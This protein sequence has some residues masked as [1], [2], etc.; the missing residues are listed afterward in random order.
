M[1]TS[2]FYR[3][4]LAGKIDLTLYCTGIEYDESTEKDD[5][6]TIHLNNVPYSLYDN[7]AFDEDGLVTVQWG[8]IGGGSIKKEVKIKN[9]EPSFDEGLTCEVKCLDAGRGMK[10]AEVSKV[11]QKVTTNQIAQQIAERNG[12]KFT[13]AAKLTKVW[14]NMPQGNRTDFDMLKYLVSQ[15]EGGDWMAVIKGNQLVIK[16]RDVSQPSTT[17]FTFGDGTGRCLSFKPQIKET[18]QKGDSVETQAQGF[19]MQAKEVVEG[20]ANSSTKQTVLTNAKTYKY[21]ANGNEIGTPIAT[22]QKDMSAGTTKAEVN[23]DAKAKFN[24]AGMGNITAEL[25][26]IGEPGYKADMVLTVAGVPKRY[27]GNYYAAGCKHSVNN[28]SWKC[29]FDLKKNSGGGSAAVST[30][31]TVGAGSTPG[32]KTK[33]YVYDAN[34][35]LLP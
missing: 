8:W 33:V 11:F 14:D 32:K 28:D 9:I 2:P 1:G 24:A 35:K 13:P 19:D 17:T 27:S 20:N 21:D 30:N 34:G 22:G 7:A 26:S 3:V 23:A 5:M 31:T 25:T 12:L 6:L 18:D 15:E 4:T 29:V 16:Q 10:K